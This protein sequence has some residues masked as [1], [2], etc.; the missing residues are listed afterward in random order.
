V[1]F[2]SAERAVPAVVAHRR[3]TSEGTVVA[4]GRNSDEGWLGGVCAGLA[5]TTGLPVLLLR[6]AFVLVPGALVAYPV[7]WLVLPDDS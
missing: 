5:D 2:G 1:T 4:L 6:L 7:L 3:Q